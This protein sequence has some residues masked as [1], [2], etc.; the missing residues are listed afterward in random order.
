MA[1]VQYT[2]P[3]SLYYYWLGDKD[4]EDKD[5]SLIKRVFNKINQRRPSCKPRY[6]RLQAD[7]HMAEPGI[8]HYHQ[9]QTYKARNEKGRATVLGKKEEKI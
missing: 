3:R 9:Q 2:D 8:R 4:C 5:V 1:S 6:I 7:D